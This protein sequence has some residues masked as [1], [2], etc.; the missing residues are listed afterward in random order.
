MIKELKR[1]AARSPKKLWNHCLELEG[2]I[3]SQIS[4]DIFKIEG[5]VPETAITG[6]TA[7]ISVISDHAWYDWV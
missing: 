1:G 5:G 6:D 2:F 7:N 3:L 4:F